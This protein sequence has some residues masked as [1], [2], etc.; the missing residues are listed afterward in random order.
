MLT[1]VGRIV[2]LECHGRLQAV[3]CCVPSLQGHVGGECTMFLLACRLLQLPFV[4]LL[5]APV[6]LAARRVEA[7]LRGVNP[8]AL[9]RH[10]ITCSLAL[11]Q[12]L[13]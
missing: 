10:P 9:S 7:P 5:Q 13:V 8:R 6:W 4:L 11:T 1:C 3:P 12:R 2:C